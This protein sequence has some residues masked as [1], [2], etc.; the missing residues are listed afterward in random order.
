MV[1]SIEN[2]CKLLSYADDS[3]ILFSHKNPELISAKLGLVLEGCSEWLV[4]NK[5]SLH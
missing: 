1:T 4:D 3:T 5:L 2:D